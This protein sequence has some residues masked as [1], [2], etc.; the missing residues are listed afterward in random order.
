[1]K[2][3]LL[4]FAAALFFAIGLAGGIV[5]AGE[6]PTNP[7]IISCHQTYEG[8]V[9]SQCWKN[10]CPEEDGKPCKLTGSMNDWC[11]LPNL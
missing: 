10:V 11:F 3:R 8:R 7:V 9:L 6:D 5:F 4:I 2:K 1:M